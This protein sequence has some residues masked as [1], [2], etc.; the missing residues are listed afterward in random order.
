ML[1]LVDREKSF[2][3]SR[4]ITCMFLAKKDKSVQF[5]HSYSLEIII[6]IIK[7]ADLCNS[8]SSKFKTHENQIH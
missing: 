7:L 4:P 8:R 6:I 1:S 3:T 5:I 2:L